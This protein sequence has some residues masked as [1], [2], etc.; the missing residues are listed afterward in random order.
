MRST[1]KGQQYRHTPAF[2][3][4]LLAQA[5]AYGASLLNR[6][7]RELPAYRTDSAIIYRTLQDLEQGGAVES[8]WD[9]EQSGPGRKWYKITA[10][11]RK[12]LNEFREDIAMR[13][14][15]L[16]YFLKVHDELGQ[17][18]GT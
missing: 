14:Q 8:Y 6:L 1:R 17:E 4:L 15:N 13:H 10:I 2:I 16:S 5:D 11:G 3:L 18:E 9:H 12:T 7:E